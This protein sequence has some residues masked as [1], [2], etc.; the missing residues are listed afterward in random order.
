M[1]DL[2]PADRPAADARPVSPS[3][4][5]GPGTPTSPSTPAAPRGPST[6]P[7]PR[8]LAAPRGPT[9]PGAAAPAPAPALVTVRRTVEADW[10]EVRRLRL[11]ML[12]DTPLAYLETLEQAQRRSEGEWRAKARE[13]SSGHAITVVA[14]VPDGRFVATM[15]SSVP[16]GASGAYLFGVYV[17][18]SHRG[19]AGV[20]DAL[21]DRIEAWAA[22]RGDSLTLEVHEE[23][24]RARAAYAKRGF[25]ETGATRPYPLDPR[26]REIEMRKALRR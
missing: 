10:P 18:P 3:T 26:S 7:A 2:G 17:A 5:A 20:T 19:P 25:I 22:G 24:L 9:I 21:L 12:R 13:G 14:E 23:N 4:P 6:P 15:L 11:E 8:V 1:F 16:R